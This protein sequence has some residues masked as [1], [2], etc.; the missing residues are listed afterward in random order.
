MKILDYLKENIL[1]FDGAMGTML[2]RAGLS[3]GEI[4]ESYN[5]TNPDIVYRIHKCYVRQVRI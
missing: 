2:Q 3:A 1:I 5:I 4:P